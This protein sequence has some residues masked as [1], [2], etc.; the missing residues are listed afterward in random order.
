M[1][2]AVAGVNTGEAWRK[3]GP[4]CPPGTRAIMSG[5]SRSSRSP[6][7]TVSE[8][9]EALLGDPGRFRPAAEA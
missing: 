1:S 8:Q 4:F 2:N 5:M 7:P 3:H 6:A 9:L